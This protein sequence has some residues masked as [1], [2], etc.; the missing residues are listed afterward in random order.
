MKAVVYE[1][2]GSPDV[3]QLREI[4][5]PSVADDEVLVKVHAASIQQT[6]INFRTG[7]PFL[8]RVLAG[9][10]KPKNQILG[11]DYSGTVEAT[12]KNV[13]EYSVGDEV[14]GQLNKRTGTHAE[15]ISVSMKEVSP[16][17]R[18]L[19]FVEAA[20]VG[21]AGTM[22]LQCLR[23]HGEIQQGVLVNGASGGIGTFAVQI[24]KSYGTEVTGVCSTANLE[25][26]K[27]IGADHV[28]DY[29]KEDFTERVDEY[30]IIFDA[31]RKNTFA[32]CKNALTSKG[33]YVT[34]EF[35]PGIMLQMKMNSNPNRKRMVG[36]LGKTDPADLIF[37]TGLIEA[38]KI[39]PVIDRTY[40]LE[41]IADAHRYVEK[42]H[43]KGKV[44]I[45]IA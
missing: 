2:Y 3:L 5:K 33:I 8:A 23:D 13:D 18:N 10:F 28:I 40:P 35:G 20:S 43:A 32:N 24:A 41:E 44:I 27:S 4:D 7:T 42:G 9:L 29:T 37:L 34:T 15:Y 6:D 16:K 11:C 38:G 30:D 45:K 19:N 22:A 12:G 14:Y 17:P 36:W 1:K 39:R 31:V 21:V 26:V 25:M